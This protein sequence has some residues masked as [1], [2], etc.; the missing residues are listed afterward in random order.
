M[1]TLTEKRS[2]QVALSEAEAFIRLIPR[3]CY[4]R[5]E[6][7]GSV[8]RKRPECGDVELVVIPGF[9]EAE[10]DMGL[11]TNREPVNLINHWL[12]EQVDAGYM[13]KAICETTGF[14]WGP[15]YHSVDWQGVRLKF[16]ASTREMWG[17]TL[18]IRTGPLELSLKL[19][20]GLN[21]NGYR[22]IDGAVW[23]CDW[24]KP[25]QQSL[26]DCDDE[27]VQKCKACDNTLLVPREI[28]SVPD[29]ERYFAL[30]G[31]P[32]CVPEQRDETVKRKE[33]S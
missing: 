23:R 14:G 18:A 30:A 10:V 21:D 8:R 32:Y 26:R 19:V 9:G 12:D 17:S 28:V 11:F 33:R 3:R 16:F 1:G 13:G 24:C 15:R 31:V 2:W 22:T 5:I 27:D 20:V 29:E 25:C 4:Q 6:I 7:A